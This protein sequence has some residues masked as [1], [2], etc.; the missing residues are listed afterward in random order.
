MPILTAE[1]LH[2]LLKLETS[3]SDLPAHVS[4]VQARLPHLIGSVPCDPSCYATCLGLETVTFR[5]ETPQTGVASGSGRADMSLQI[6]GV[7][8]EDE[9]HAWSK[10][11]PLFSSTAVCE[12]PRPFRYP[13]NPQ[14]IRPSWR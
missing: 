2:S 13:L 12:H 11:K 5:G 3:P 7:Y 8:E 1:R 4:A 6:R 10:V 9:V 14:S